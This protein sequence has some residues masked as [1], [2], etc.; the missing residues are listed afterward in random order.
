[1]SGAKPPAAAPGL[2]LVDVVDVEEGDLRRFVRGRDRDQQQQ[3]GKQACGQDAE[4]THDDF[5]W[6]HD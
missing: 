5:S 2:D 6:L 4:C 1:M 3:D